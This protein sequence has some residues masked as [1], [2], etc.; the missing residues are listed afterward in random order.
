VGEAATYVHAVVL[1]STAVDAAREKR[2]E[3]VERPPRSLIAPQ[4]VH[5]M[6]EFEPKTY[7]TSPGFL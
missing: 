6:R 5:V 4:R 2:C 3:A 7:N 1:C